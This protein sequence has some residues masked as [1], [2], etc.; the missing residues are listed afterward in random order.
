MAN[1]QI[2]CPKGHVYDNSLSACPYCSPN[3]P[4]ISPLP[5]PIPSSH[6]AKPV[7]GWLIC[8]QGNDYGKDFRLHAGFNF[9][10]RAENQDVRLKDNSVSREHFI[11]SY[12]KEHNIY[13]AEISK[14]STMVYINGN[15]LGG[16]VVLKKDDQ[17]RVGDTLLIFVPFEQQAV[18]WNWE[19]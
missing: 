16:K 1:K 7:V 17:I 5:P 11:V 10:G 4:P 2:T 12:D 8:I 9:V 14:G 15:A 13:C 19:I 3:P 6:H 18:K